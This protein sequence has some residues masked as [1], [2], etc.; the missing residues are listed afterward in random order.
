MDSNLAGIRFNH[1]LKSRTI[2]SITKDI[3]KTDRLISKNV[4][5]LS[6]SGSISV[7]HDDRLGVLFT[8]VQVCLTTPKVSDPAQVLDATG[9]LIRGLFAYGEIVGGVF[10]HGY[11]GGSGLTSGT[12]FGRLVG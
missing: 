3:S 11:P 4:K 12:I 6:Q 5:L 9:T 7:P 8:G 10:L 2:T 1:R